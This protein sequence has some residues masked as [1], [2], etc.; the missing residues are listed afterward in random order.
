MKLIQENNTLYIVEGENKYKVSSELH[1]FLMVEHLGVTIFDGF[2]YKQKIVDRLRIGIDITDI[3]HRIEIRNDNGNG[4]QYSEAFLLPE[5]EDKSWLDGKDL[6]WKDMSPEEV[7]AEALPSLTAKY[8][9]SQTTLGGVRI[10]DV[11]YYSIEQIKSAIN[12]V[13]LEGYQI[14]TLEREIINNLTK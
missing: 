7:K 1:N 11:Q 3:Q 9:L 14:E 6:S 10:N 8:K 5:K 12:Q 2:D 4:C 13:V